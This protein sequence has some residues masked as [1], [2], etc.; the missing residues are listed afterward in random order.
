MQRWPALAVDS[1]RRVMLALR[2]QPAAIGTPP[3]ATVA[4]LLP[5]DLGPGEVLTVNAVLATP[6]TPGRYDLV[7]EVRQ[8]G[9]RVRTPGT[10]DVRV[11][12]GVS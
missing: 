7:A 3:S 11:T 10:N 8:G 12:V 4:V 6:S 2:W 1:Q 5:R 9:T